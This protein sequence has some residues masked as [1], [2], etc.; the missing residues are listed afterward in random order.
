M[1]GQSSGNNGGQS[2]ADILNGAGQN[3]GN[4]GGQ[5][6]GNNGGQNFGNN[7]G[8]NSGNNG[9]Q[10]SGNNGGQNSGNNGAFTN[11]NNCCCSSTNGQLNN[12]GDEDGFDGL[13]PRSGPNSTVNV[14]TGGDEKS[15]LASL[16][17]DIGVR[18]VNNA[19]DDAF[20]R[21]NCPL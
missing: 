6:F 15:D 7:G 17:A 5:N 11:G 4:N 16:A 2:F 21:G 10:N 18:I 12:G 13:V 20:T 14:R 3:S 1:G 9:G 8:Q 19:P